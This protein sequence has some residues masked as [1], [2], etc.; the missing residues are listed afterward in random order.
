[1][2]IRGEI[3][4]EQN[5]S[6]SESEESGKEEEVAV[7]AKPKPKAVFK[8]KGGDETDNLISEFL[9]NTQL[10]VGNMKIKKLGKPRVSAHAAR[11]A[12]AVP[13]RQQEG[14]CKSAEW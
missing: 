2:E 7:E 4:A 9:K 8:P 5:A 13:F 1:M 12:R 6:K 14:V 3:E 11:Q 10:D